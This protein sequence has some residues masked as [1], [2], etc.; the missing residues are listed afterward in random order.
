MNKIVRFIDF[1]ST[2]EAEFD[3]TGSYPYPEVFNWGNW[4]IK[5]CNGKDLI[6]FD[7]ETRAFSHEVTFLKESAELTAL[8]IPKEYSRS[9]IITGLYKA[10]ELLGR[11]S[12]RKSY[13]DDDKDLEEN[14]GTVWYLNE[15]GA[16]SAYQRFYINGDEGEARRVSVNL[17]L[18]VNYTEELI[19]V[20]IKWLK[21]ILQRLIPVLRIFIDSGVKEKVQKKVLSRVPKSFVSEKFQPD[22]VNSLFKEFVKLGYLVD[23]ES[24]RES[25]SKLLRAKRET[26]NPINPKLDWRSYETTLRGFIVVI[27]SKFEIPDINQSRWR[28]ADNSFTIRGKPCNLSKGTTNT[29]YGSPSSVEAMDRAIKNALKNYEPSEE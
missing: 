17:E 23:D 4:E 20:D 11:I 29:Y 13:F 18:L 3:Y 7:T 26:S 2:I 21:D 16:I 28:T 22:V 14:K 6:E 1:F 12:S 8:K 27:D 10:E 25:F 24:Q 9:G 19:S 15:K 5:L